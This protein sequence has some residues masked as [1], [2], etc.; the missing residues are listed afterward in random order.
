V[1]VLYQIHRPAC[2]H[3]GIVSALGRLLRCSECD[4]VRLFRKGSPIK[5]QTKTYAAEADE[6]AWERYER[7]GRFGLSA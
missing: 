4:A 7:G 6:E 2:G 5:A 3:I 1:G